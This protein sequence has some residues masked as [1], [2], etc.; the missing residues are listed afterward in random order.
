MQQILNVVRPTRNDEA[1][2]CRNG[3]D[4]YDEK[5]SRKGC[6][7]NL[8]ALT[9][10]RCMRMRYA[11]KASF[12]KVSQSFSLPDEVDD[13]LAQLIVRGVDRQSCRLMIVSGEA[14]KS[15]TL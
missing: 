4:Y 12:A 1:T 2:D 6:F 3:L 5:H 7:L 13:L 8:I 15:R 14:Q 10:Q 11:P 9:A